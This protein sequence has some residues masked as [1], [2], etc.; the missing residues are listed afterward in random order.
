LLL[1]CLFVCIQFMWA[2]GIGEFSLSLHGALWDTL[3][4]FEICADINHSHNHHPIYQATTVLPQWHRCISILP[5][6]YRRFNCWWTMGP[7]VQ[8]LALQP[9]HSHTQWQ[10]RAW[11]STLGCVPRC[12]SCSL[13]PCPLWTNSATHSPSC[14]PCSCVGHYGLCASLIHNCYLSLCSG[15]LPSPCRARQLVDQF[16]ENYRYVMTSHYILMM[17]CG[18]TLTIWRGLLRYLLPDSVGR[19][20]W[21]CSHVWRSR[22]HCWSLH[23]LCHCD[24]DLGQEVEGQSRT[25]RC[26]KLRFPRVEASTGIL[27]LHCFSRFWE[28]FSRDAFSF[29]NIYKLLPVFSRF[30]WIHPI[31]TL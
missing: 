12:R 1:P 22:C 14:G 15:L 10:V 25:A 31:R 16:L 2:I 29:E 19:K 20:V 24:P 21:G 26:W 23:V 3:N 6:S 5:C 27:S 4:C 13:L 8:W 17:D 30:C 18:P 9:L 28:K 7:L 11:K